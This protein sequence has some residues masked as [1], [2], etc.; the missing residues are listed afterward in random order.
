VLDLDHDRASRGDHD[1]VDLVRLP[2]A[3]YAVREIGENKGAIFARQCLQVL[4]DSSECCFFA[5]V[6]KRPADQMINPHASP[7][8]KCVERAYNLNPLSEPD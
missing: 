8:S 3:S 5:G 1:H 7:Q 6:R 2:T 4:V